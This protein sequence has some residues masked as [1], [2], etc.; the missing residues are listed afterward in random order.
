MSKLK[1]VLL[2]LCFHIPLCYI[3]IKEVL[4]FRALAQEKSI[5]IGQ[6]SDLSFMF[7]SIFIVAALKRVLYF[8]T[9]DFSE[10]RIAVK[11][12]PDHDARVA[13]VMCTQF[14]AIFYTLTSIFAFYMYWGHPNLYNWVSGPASTGGMFYNWP[15]IQFPY[16]KEFIMLQLGY[17]MHNFLELFVEKRHTS[18]FVQFFIHHLL[19][20]TEIMWS[21]YTNNYGA[22]IIVLLVHDV[23]DIPLNL[24]KLMRDLDLMSTHI[25]ILDCVF[26][27]I[28][29]SWLYFRIIVPFMTYLPTAY[30]ILYTHGK[31]C[32]EGIDIMNMGTCCTTLDTELGLSINLTYKL[33]IGGLLIF[34]FLN[35]IWFYQIIACGVNKKMTGEYVSNYEGEKFKK[36]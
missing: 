17:H 18:Q 27:C 25:K 15:Y 31:C 1:I 32:V 22:A 9:K 23:C 2:T 6:W 24:A 13:K 20:I 12:H 5:P 19:T 28:P 21:Y 34:V 11:N 3:N 30:D 33:Q 35:L 26:L 16:Q 4:N 10:R 14:Q 7:Y 36:E 29:L 8:F